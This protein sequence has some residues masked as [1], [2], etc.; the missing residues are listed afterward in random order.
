MCRWHLP[1]LL[2]LLLAVLVVLLLLLHLLWG[3]L[4]QQRGAAVLSSWSLLCGT[5]LRCHERI[6][7]SGSCVLEPHERAHDIVHNVF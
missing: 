7:E 4:L 3:L 1:L 2:L 5:A 6:Q